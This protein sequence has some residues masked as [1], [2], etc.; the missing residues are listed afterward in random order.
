MV[1][2]KKRNQRLRKRVRLTTEAAGQQTFSASGLPKIGSLHPV[3]IEH[4]MGECGDGKQY[5]TARVQNLKHLIIDNLMQAAG[6]YLKH[7]EDEKYR[8]NCHKPCLFLQRCTPCKAMLPFPQC[9]NN[10]LHLMSAL[11]I[12][13]FFIRG[14]FF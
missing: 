7:D 1:R 11:A 8:I 3:P 4:Q 10:L 5:A 13:I 2:S 9:F 6:G 12:E 14:E